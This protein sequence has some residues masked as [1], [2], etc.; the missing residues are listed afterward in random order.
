[1]INVFTIAF[2]DAAFS[3]HVASRLVSGR[4]LFLHPLRAVMIA[5][6]FGIVALISHG[7]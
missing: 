7:E 6:L 5:I 1:M 3:F 4:S 2:M